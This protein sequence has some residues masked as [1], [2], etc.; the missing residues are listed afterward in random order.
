MRSI[1]IIEIPDKRS[2]LKNQAGGCTMGEQAPLAIRDPPF[3]GADPPAAAQHDALGPDLSVFGG[4]G[5]RHEILNSSVVW[6]TPF[7]SVDWTANPIQLSSS[8]AAR[9]PCTVPAGLRWMPLGSA[10]TTTRPLAASVTS[11]PKVWA[12]VLRGSVPSTS[13]WTN[14]RPLIA[15]CRSALTVPNVLLAVRLGITVIS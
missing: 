14:S 11:Y 10:V 7:S 8:V 4:I 6:P 13:P 5:R 15:F 2:S 3:G 12:I 1:Y 9:P